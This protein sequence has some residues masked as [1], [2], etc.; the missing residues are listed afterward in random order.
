MASN[1]KQYDPSKTLFK[2]QQIIKF[3]YAGEMSFLWPRI[4]HTT[5]FLPVFGIHQ[6]SS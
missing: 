2:Q 4:A 6:K 3:S 1:I 5:E